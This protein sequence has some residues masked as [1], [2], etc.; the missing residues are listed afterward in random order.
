MSI[1]KITLSILV[2]TAV[3]F[4]GCVQLEQAIRDK[5]LV[6][7]R[8]N[9]LDNGTIADGIREALKVGSERAVASSSKVDGYLGNQ[10]I[11][12]ATPS[13]LSK[14]SKALRKIG[15]S[16]EVD[17]FEVA[18]NRAAEQSASQ[19]KE[20]F[21]T[22]IRQM[23]LRDVRDIWKGGD[24][25]ATRYFRSKTEQTLYG[26]FHPIVR[27]KMQTVGLYKSYNS[28]VN[29]YMKIPFVK[30]PSL[31][32]DQYVTQKTLDGL[33]LVLAQ[34]EARIRKDPV[35]RT[36]ELLRKVFG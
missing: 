22:V 15:L 32:L 6:S 12:I 27:N 25:A 19:T 14:V 7:G 23:T 20:I 11:R 34:E 24:D 17:N 10:L 31:D 8:S 18:M 21:W 36:T 35:A 16:R 30:K 33:Y 1:Q 5:G 3:L 29:S 9:S 13:E 2:M 28:M 4:S 26:R